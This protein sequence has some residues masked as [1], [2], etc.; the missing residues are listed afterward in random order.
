MINFETS[1]ELPASKSIKKLRISKIIGNLTHIYQHTPQ[2]NKR[3]ICTGPAHS[4][5]KSC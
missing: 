1:T 2:T 3:T 5:D 4:Q